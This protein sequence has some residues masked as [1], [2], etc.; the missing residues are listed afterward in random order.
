M[1]KGNCKNKNKGCNW[2]LTASKILRRY[3]FTNFYNKDRYKSVF[4]EGN[5]GYDESK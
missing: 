1:D 3:A 5:E 2:I 4:R